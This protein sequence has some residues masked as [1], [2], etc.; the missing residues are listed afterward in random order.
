MD[1]HKAYQ[2][3]KISKWK[4]VTYPLFCLKSLYDR[5]ISSIKPIKILN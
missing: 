2:A 3:Q 5:N 1:R 4:K